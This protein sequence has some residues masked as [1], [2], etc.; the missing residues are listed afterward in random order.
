MKYF[1][2]LLMLL[3]AQT[4]FAQQNNNEYGILVG[5]LEKIEVEKD[6]LPAQQVLP[7]NIESE[8]MKIDLPF[9]PIIIEDADYSGASKGQFSVSLTGAATYNLPIEVPPGIN[10][11]SPKIGL[12]YSSQASNGIAGYGWTISGLSSISKVGSNK[13]FDGKNSIINYSEDDRFMLDGQRLL[14][15][16]GNYGLDGAEYQTET[17]S[18][19]KITSH[20]NSQSNYEPEYFKVQYP[21]G[22]IAYYGKRYNGLLVGS[23]GSPTRT[24]TVYALTYLMNPQN[25]VINYHYIVDN[26]NL[27]VSSIKYGYRS[28]NPLTSLLIING[29]NNISFTYKNRNRIET[30]YI[31]GESSQATK[32]LDKITVKGYAENY[33]TYQLTYTTTSLGYERLQK[34]TETSGDST[35]SKKPVSFSYGPDITSENILTEEAFVI[36]DNFG[37]GF[38]KLS[39]H[40]SKVLTGDFSGSGHIGFLMMGTSV[41]DDY[42]QY[43]DGSKLY[44]YNPSDPTD[45]FDQNKPLIFKQSFTSKPFL[46]VVTS[47]RLNH[48]NI[49]LPN[50][51][52]TTV[53]QNSVNGDGVNYTF[54]SYVY[55]PGTALT[56]YQQGDP[57]TVTMYGKPNVRRQFLSG[58]F[59]G[60]GITEIV[61]M[62][63][64]RNFDDEGYNQYSTG[65]EILDTTTGAVYATPNIPIGF[66][67]QVVDVD[68][69]G[70]DEFIV[71]RHQNIRIYKFNLITKKLDLYSDQG[72]PDVKYG[73]AVYLGD[74]NGDGKL[75]FITPLSPAKK[76]TSSNQWIF[77]INKD[78][79]DFNHF[80]KNIGIPYNM[81][82][83]SYY[84]TQELSHT[85]YNYI[86]SD[87]N[88]DGKT[89]I[90]KTLDKSLVDYYGNERSSYM[91]AVYT[92][93]NLKFDSESQDISFQ[94][95]NGSY[96]LIS[97]TNRFPIIVNSNFNQKN[98]KTELA[99][100]T[101]NK[102]KILKSNK[103]NVKTQTLSTINEF[104]IITK[105]TYNVY[106][107]GKNTRQGVYDKLEDA[108][109]PFTSFNQPMPVYPKADIDII[110][111]MYLVTKVTYDTQSLRLGETTERKQ[112]FSYADPTISYNGKGFLGFKGRMVT[113]I[114]IGGPSIYDLQDQVKNVTIFDLDN[115]GLVKEE[116]VA[117]S[118]D[119]ANFFTTPVNFLTKKVNTYNIT[120]LSNKVFKAQN[121]KSV[122]NEGLTG[123]QRTINSTYDAYSNPL[124]VTETVTGGG[125]TSTLNSVFTYNLS[126]TN[127]NYYIG[128][129]ASKTIKMNNV[130]TSKEVYTYA[131][132]L[133]TNVTKQGAVGSSELSETNEFDLF[134]NVIKKTISSSGIQPRIA[135]YIYDTS[136][137]YIEKSIDV[138]GLETTY[139]YNKNKGWLLSQTNPYGLTN[140]FGY[141][142]LGMT[143]TETDYLGNTT[144]FAYKT[145]SRFDLGSSFVRKETNYA[146][147]RKE[148]VTTNAWGNKSSEGYTDIE[149]NW[150]NTS[151]SYDS[152]D[153]LIKKSDPY[154]STASLFTTFEYDK[155]GR[156]IKTVLPTGREITASYSGLSSTIND[157]VKTKTETKNANNQTKKVVDNGETIN[158]SYNPNGTLK[159][160]NYAGIIIS[161]EYDGWGRKTKMADPS[162]GTYTYQYNSIGDL[163]KE[164]TPNGNT[165]YTYDA[166]G[167]I[168]TTSHSG[169]NIAY[170]YNADKLPTNIITNSADGPYVE[171]FTYDSY[172]RI[173]AK[174]YTTP[175]GFTYNYTYTFDNLGR[176]LTEEKKVTG[177]SGTDAVKT[178][179]VY[180]NGYLWKLQNAATNTDLK[181]YNSFNQRGQVTSFT[182]ANGLVTNRTYDQYGYLTQ[183]TVNKNNIAFFTLNNTWDVQ[184]GNLTSRSNTLFTGGINETFQ[185]DTFDR[186]TNNS[187]K[188]GAVIIAQETNTYDGKGRI[189]NNNV[190]DYNYDSA[191]AYQLQNVENLNDLAYYQNNPLQ[192]V[193]YNTHKAPL[194]I[195]QQ[196]KENIYFKYDGFDKRVAMYYGNEAADETASSK[197]RYYS[198][199][200]DIE[201]DFDKATNKYIVNMYVDGDPYS[202]SIIQRKENNATTF[203][204]LHRDYLGSILAVTNSTGAIV[205]KRHFDAWGNVLLVQNGQNIDLGKL[206]FLER[207]YTGHE[208]LQGV[209][210]INMNARLYDPKLHRFLAPDNFI[211]DAGNPQNYNLYGYGLNNP[212][213]YT[214]PTG[215]FWHIVI[216]AAIGGIVNWAT[217]GAQF[218]A[219]G[220]GYFGIGAGVGALAA[221]TGG[222]VTSV[223]GGG[224]FMAGALGS[225]AAAGIGSG[226][227]SGAIGGFVTGSVSGFSLSLANSMYEGNSFKNSLDVALK[228]AL[229]SGT[230]SAVTAGLISGSIAS[231]QGL[232][233]WTGK[234][235]IAHSI[236][237]NNDP[238]IGDGE[239][240]YNNEAAMSFAKNNPDTSQYLKHVKNL[241]AD[242]TV[243]K[244]YLTDG[245]NMY[246]SD[247]SLILGATESLG[248]GKSNVYLSNDVFRTKVQLFMTMKHEFMHAKLNALGVLSTSMNDIQHKII[249]TW[250]YDQVNKFINLGASPLD[251]SNSLK[252][253]IINRPSTIFNFYNYSNYGFKT[254]NYLP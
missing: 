212:L 231:E 188:Q 166:T 40:N 117:H 191:K 41:N 99:L 51:G 216:G 138:E 254:I 118:T 236:T 87:I 199:A 115:N 98:Y 237:L 197:I 168:A 244:G 74:F 121:T 180:K 22:S 252:Y 148:K 125:E 11:V 90:I 158:Y 251:F 165:V 18:N 143:M 5:G 225:S 181:I 31:F 19:L 122:I 61:R 47:K 151:Y 227:I 193:T 233:F 136:G 73:K 94:L 49:L 152:Q 67:Y 89:D 132:H 20:G 169:K 131:N 14:L 235:V 200:G 120:N 128:R 84:S 190:G 178:K 37:I 24:N 78:N 140:S 111:G 217:H 50:L 141:N 160:T 72:M 220:L 201:V 48:S 249:N 110:P 96:Q 157:G 57:I 112:L 142:A 103:D 175:L 59:N 75:D 15:K 105:I 208:H 3:G 29:Y 194:T 214:D 101:D 198:P 81:D 184:R 91:T 222:G 134:G 113:N 243:P 204:Y 63:H 139:V 230:I 240:A 219:K 228:S 97:H 25:V 123:I 209:G 129:P 68:G 83:K 207:G 241:Y 114:Y 126:L 36:K 82:E 44:V 85:S 4:I 223:L 53:T 145:N 161:F 226:F 127:D 33:R 149:G 182:L 183:N 213:R 16:S 146:D 187:T 253:L 71:I 100:L 43:I 239:V 167:K 55:V 12:T 95:P 35:I 224:S 26:G 206:T 137:R 9:D 46:D 177:A 186:L 92:F 88:N 124:T 221:F 179:N 218:N 238:F 156:V 52:W 34:I 162:A 1:Y 210:L 116:Y 170:N 234:G 229:V 153:R 69:D 93:E 21:D 205:E 203:Y 79:G 155:Y 130:Q 6:T 250:E 247:G 77:Y 60:D 185:Y 202:A 109:V 164:T 102:L 108:V 215:N 174:K 248:F 172:K 246:D 70:Y 80:A 64:G 30:G 7:E 104:D 32:I 106:D 23:I 119:W 54:N 150:I 13:F 39:S 10:G 176:V 154:T 195:K 76:E 147:G 66:N 56:V 189:L 135:S 86:F 196:G 171:N 232:N 242:G 245:W 211:Q 107:K 27:L 173:T 2:F 133:L 8:T 159:N 45:S 192:Q 28:T 65:V 58:D 38:S 144:N 163:L 42:M 62:E 17:Y